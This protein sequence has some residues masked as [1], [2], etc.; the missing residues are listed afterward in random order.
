MKTRQDK[1]SKP[2]FDKKKT[3]DISLKHLVTF[4]FPCPNCDQPILEGKLYCSEICSQEAHFVR[5]VRRCHQDGRDQQPDVREAIDI[6]LAM[7]L[8]GGYPEQE[9]RL[10]D[11]IRKAVIERDKGCCQKCGQPGDQID[12]IR[13]N[14]DD[15]KNLQLLCRTCHNQKTKAGF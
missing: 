9:R 2:N 8:S 10:T 5:Y 12:H 3:L 11:S 6:K 14:S 1:K 15:M 4:P 7:I 13:G